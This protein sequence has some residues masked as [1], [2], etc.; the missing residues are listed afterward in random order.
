MAERRFSIAPLLVVPPASAAQSYDPLWASDGNDKGDFL[1]CAISTPYAHHT[2]DARKRHSASG[3]KPVKVRRKTGPKSGIA[4]CSLP[5]APARLV[6]PLSQSIR[7]RY[8]FDFDCFE[9]SLFDSPQRHC[10][11][12]CRCA[13]TSVYPRHLSVPRCCDQFAISTQHC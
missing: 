3:R 5:R 1:R 11:T 12:G 9:D 10:L 8:V 4:E 13:S 2:C 6:A 7:G